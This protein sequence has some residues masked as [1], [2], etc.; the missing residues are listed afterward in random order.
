MSSKPT[1]LTT[2]PEQREPQT[3]GSA[4]NNEPTPTGAL[5]VDDEEEEDVPETVLS[6]ITPEERVVPV[7]SVPLEALPS[8]SHAAN[9]LPEA[10]LNPSIRDDSVWLPQYDDSTM[11]LQQWQDPGWFRRLF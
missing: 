3:T 8:Q 9:M 10:N 7:T 5:P 2:V 11:V 4:T 6:I 1:T